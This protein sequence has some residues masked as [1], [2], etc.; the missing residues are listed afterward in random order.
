MFLKEI[1]EQILRLIRCIDSYY[2][3]A[4]RLT[5]LLAF[6]LRQLLFRLQNTEMFTFA[7]KY[8]AFS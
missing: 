1:V 2:S 6:Q 7:G 5:F 4:Q 3:K 8:T